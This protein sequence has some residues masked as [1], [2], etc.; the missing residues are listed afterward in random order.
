MPYLTTKPLQDIGGEIKGTDVTVTHLKNMLGRQYKK[1][2]LNQ[3]MEV[4]RVAEE[5][6]VD[7]LSKAEVQEIT[8]KEILPL[9]IKETER[10]ANYNRLYDNSS[11]DTYNIPRTY[12]STHIYETPILT[13]TQNHFDNMNYF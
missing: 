10:Y 9:E 12:G 5:K 4:I 11:L 7:K 1:Q 2:E 13:S 8:R 3:I 6:G